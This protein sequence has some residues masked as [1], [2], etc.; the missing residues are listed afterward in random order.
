MKHFKTLLIPLLALALVLC[1]CGQTAAPAE[2]AAPQTPT[3]A[4]A[5]TAEPIPSPAADVPEETPAASGSDLGYEPLPATDGDLSAWV[6]A[7][8]PVRV[9]VLNGPTGFGMARLICDAEDGNASLNY[10]FSVESDASN[11][12]AALISGSTDIAVLPTNAASAVWNKT[13]GG[14][15]VAAEVVRG[16]LYLLQNTEKEA[17]SSVEDLRGKTVYVPAQNP[18]FITQ[19]V[20]QQ[21]GLTPGVDVEIDNSYAQPADLR[22]ALAAGEV[23]LAV[24]PEPMVTIAM[25][26]NETLAVA[27]DLREA[28]RDAVGSDSLVMGCVVVRSAFAEE[29]PVELKE[30]LRNYS[31]SV[32]YV[33][34]AA[35]AEAAGELI[36]RAGVFAQAKVAEKA[37]PRCSLCFVTGEQ[38]R[39]ELGAYLEQLFALNPAA[40]GGSVP[41]DSFYYLP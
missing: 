6:D 38:M 3:E 13:E 4:P 31:D 18:T 20:L 17:I 30:F 21:N 33:G 28:W 2:T 23:D 19:L 32:S 8:L 12:S 7:E 35:N 14:I 16:N 5:Q 37:L 40:V 1:A 11:V 15:M 10:S 26:A 36:A 39:E 27:L 41:D 34:D 22:T 24:L 29:H 9:M 25:S